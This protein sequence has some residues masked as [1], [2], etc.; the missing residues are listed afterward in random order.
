MRCWCRRFASRNTL[1]TYV[2]YGT[3]DNTTAPESLVVRIVR[4][5]DA[6]V[7]WSASYPVAGA[8]PAQI[9]TDVD[10]RLQS[11]EEDE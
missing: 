6:T 7:L 5:A 11:L 8:D 2:L 9:A 4:T 1:P 3:I 10:S